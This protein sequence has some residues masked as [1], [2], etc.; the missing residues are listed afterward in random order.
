MFMACMLLFLH[1]YFNKIYR[2]LGRVNLLTLIN[3]NRLCT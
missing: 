3:A 2:Y 1:R